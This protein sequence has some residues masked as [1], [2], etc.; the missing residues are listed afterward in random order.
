M[1][2]FIGILMLDTAFPRILGDAGNSDSYPFPVRL[3]IVPGAGSRDIVQGARP[4]AALVSAFIH[5]ARALEAEGAVGLVSTCGFLVHIQNELAA[6]LRIPVIV[7]ALTLY[8]S[9]KIALAGKPIGI[10]TASQAGLMAGTLDAAGIDPRSVHVAGMQDCPAFAE[11]IL[12]DKADQPD[13]L[14][15]TAIEA[16]CTA[17]AS[18]M[19]AQNP[20]LGGFLLECGN[21]P[22]YA[23]AIRAATG[24]P[25]FGILD[26][27]AF[28]WHGS[29]PVVE[30][31]PIQG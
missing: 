3:R 14:D 24:R 17:L 16:H 19:I 9:L 10:L 21:L 6:A 8:P 20:D 5:A 1:T 7:S 25:V 30:R 13:S 23:D 2:G 27:A 29:A 26:A 18:D 28:L 4:D 15:C 31:N 22:P 11:A 12:C